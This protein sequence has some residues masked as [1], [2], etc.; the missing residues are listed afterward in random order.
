MGTPLFISGQIG[1]PVSNLGNWTRLLPEFRL[2]QGLRFN[3]H[4]GE[5]LNRQ[6]SCIHPKRC[7]N[8]TTHMGY[9][10][11]PYVVI[12]APAGVFKNQPMQRLLGAKLRLQAT[13]T[14]HDFIQLTETSHGIQQRI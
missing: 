4:R 13:S 12:D 14:R 1:K 8:S 6:P 11:S 9:P 3:R 7:P 2:T 10:T 5:V